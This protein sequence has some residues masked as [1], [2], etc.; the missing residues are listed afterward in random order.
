MHR[1][2]DPFAAEE[3]RAADAP[4]RRGR[5]AEA[6]VGPRRQ[7]RALHLRARAQTHALR[8]G[9][10][11]G[12]RPNRRMVIALHL[13][14]CMCACACTR[15]RVRA[16]VPSNARANSRANAAVSQAA[17]QICTYISPGNCVART[18]DDC[19]I[20]ACTSSCTTLLRST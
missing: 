6:A 10:S 20:R 8:P 2:T 15:A 19:I 9:C 3:S 14:A 1:R 18:C 5:L 4:H 13:R 11:R 12:R 17:R 7:D 16:R